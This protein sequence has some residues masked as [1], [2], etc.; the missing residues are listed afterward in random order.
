[1]SKT[2]DENLNIV[3]E[4][5]LTIELMGDDLVIIQKLDDEPN[6]VGGLSADELKATFDQAGLLIQK[7]I[8]EKLIPAILA[9][10]ATEAARG[11]AETARQ[12]AETGRQSAEQ[13][14]NAA[15]TERSNAE[16]SRRNA[17][18]ARAVAETQRQSAE[19]LRKAAEAERKTAETARAADM[20]S[21]KLEHA[22]VKALIE[23]M[24]VA[25][26]TI[27]AE[28]AAA[29]EIAK[30]SATGGYRITFSIP[31]GQVGPKG[32][33]GPKG[34][35][36][37]KGDKGDPGDIEGAVKY[38]AQTLTDEQQAQARANI[39][40]PGELIDDG[41]AKLSFGGEASGYASFTEGAS[42]VASG[43]GSHAEGT[44]TRASGDYAHAEGYGSSASGE[45]AHAE[46]T[47]TVASGKSSHAEGNKAKA[48]GW[49]SHAEGH[50]AEATSLG[51]HAEGYQ[52]KAIGNWGSHAEG[53]STEASGMYGS[54]AEGFSTVASGESSHAEGTGTIAAG[55]NQHVQG[56]Y[57]VEDTLDKYAHII[58]N[59]GSKSSRANAHTVDWD[60][61]AWFKGKVLVGGTGQD[62]GEEVATKQYVDEAVANA[63]GA[64]SWNDLTDKPFGDMETGG[65]TLTWDGDTT[66]RVSVADMFYKVSDAVPTISDFENGGTFVIGPV[67]TNGS[68][69]GSDVIDFGSGVLAGPESL[70]AFVPESAV[71][72][73]VQGL[74]F[75]EAGT[76]FIYGGE[77]YLASLTIPGYT[78]F[79]TVKTLDEKYLPESVKGG[80]G[81][82]VYV[83]FTTTDG[84][85]WTPDKTFAEVDEHI[86]SGKEVVAVV[87]QGEFYL[88]FRLG[89]YIPQ[90]AISFG[91]ISNMGAPAYEQLSWEPGAT[92][93]A[94]TSTYLAVDAS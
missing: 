4:S 29:A 26:Q 15:E 23:K 73:E 9:D 90:S 51:S 88:Y 30:D 35:I 81:G 71:G 10:D 1:M 65:D 37:P 18:G 21:M 56:R 52:T 87:F 22:D 83:N 36:G 68:F 59:G 63:G 44:M 8:N 33:T 50:S 3:S 41:G 28:S 67:G 11:E 32:D 39:A 7:Y 84:E 5:G 79:P 43:Y 25:A 38:T 82:V 55:I 60:G 70:C 85:N 34:D 6:D 54:H 49:G 61:N 27:S 77:M 89:I 64:S 45:A 57:N 76:Y 20:A 80:S 94:I 16:T 14:R 75:P 66:G 12:S 24:T 2:L 93:C 78:G 46:G 74:T 42:T 72:I 62:D 31:R 69:N 40:V 48:T 19:E 92:S 17:E 86:S 91:I 53:Y 47:D 13:L 58:G